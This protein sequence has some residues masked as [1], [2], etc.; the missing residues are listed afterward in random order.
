MLSMGTHPGAV[1]LRHPGVGW[2]AV[3]RQWG[4]RLTAGAGQLMHREVRVG[5]TAEWDLREARKP[6]AV[7]EGVLGD[8]SPV[9]PTP[10]SGVQKSLLLKL[11]MPGAQPGD[12][13]VGLGDSPPSR[14]VAS[15]HQRGLLRKLALRVLGDLGYV[16][17]DSSSQPALPSL[18]KIPG[19]K[20]PRH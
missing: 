12:R 3:R 16:P 11:G 14:T 5:W 15:L 20:E 17:P 7:A 10:G 18:P 8:Y 19:T 13:Q 4:E 2:G 9:P 1:L 6:E